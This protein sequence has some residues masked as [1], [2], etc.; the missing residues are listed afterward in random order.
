MKDTAVATAE[1]SVPCP[2]CRSV[3]H[4]RHIAVE[5]EEDTAVIDGAEIRQAL[6]VHLLMSCRG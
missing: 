1:V 6:H 2:E 3:L 5:I 4:L